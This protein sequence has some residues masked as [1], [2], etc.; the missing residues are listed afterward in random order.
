V[1]YLTVVKFYL[2]VLESAGKQIDSVEDG[3]G[4]AMKMAKYMPPVGRTAAHA[5]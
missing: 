4:E 2:E 5:L 1:K 3:R